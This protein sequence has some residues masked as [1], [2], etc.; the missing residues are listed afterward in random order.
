MGVSY[1]DEQKRLES[2]KPEGKISFWKP[3]PGQYRVKALS[4]L[5]ES[6]PFKEPGKEDKPQVRISLLIDDEVKYWT[7]SVGKS[8]SSA[9]G[10][11]VNLAIKNGNKL[12]GKEFMI[13]VTFDGKKNSYAIV[14]FK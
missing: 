14:D 7:I 6:I 13:V 5:E 10:Q 4:E 1:Q 11:L 2:F 3:K 12:I 9:Y 8:Q